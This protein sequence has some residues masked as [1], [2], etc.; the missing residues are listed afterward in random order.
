MRID[1][2]SEQ[3][4]VRDEHNAAMTFFLTSLVFVLGVRDD[5]RMQKRED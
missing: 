3:G 1:D 4:W 5:R 2:L